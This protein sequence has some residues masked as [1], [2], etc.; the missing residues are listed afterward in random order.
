MFRTIFKTIFK[1]RYPSFEDDVDLNLQLMYRCERAILHSPVEWS[2]GPTL[3]GLTKGIRERI[4]KGDNKIRPYLTYWNKSNQIMRMHLY[5]GDSVTVLYDEDLMGPHVKLKSSDV[6][7]KPQ[8]R[9][10]LCSTYISL[11]GGGCMNFNGLFH[12][13]HTQDMRISN[14]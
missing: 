4:V 10:P 9:S 13:F 5:E 12:K 14:F 6:I 1:V 3:D 8:I 11:S 7:I 2:K